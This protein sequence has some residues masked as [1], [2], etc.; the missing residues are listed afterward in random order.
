MYLKSLSI[1]GFK[2]FADK[3]TLKY[4]PGI[5]VIVGPN[6]SGKSNITDAI[7][8]VLG[9]Q[10]PR[11]LRGSAME[12]VIFTGSS[13][14]SPLGIAEVSLS[15]DNTDGCLPIEFSEVI[16]T[17]RMSRSGESDY[18]INGSSCRLLDVQDLLSDSGLGR[19]THSIVS[20]GRI[21]EI[22]SSKPEEKRVLIEEVAGV[23]KHRKRKERAL[24]KL[25]AM[26]QNLL[27]I[28]DVLREV[29]RQLRPLKKQ[30]SQAEKSLKLSHQLKNL[31]IA[32][33][34]AELKKLQSGWDD[35]MKENK[36]LNNELVALR[37]RLT[38]KKEEMDE[39]QLSLEE[40]GDYVGDIGEYR[41]RMKG[42]IERFNTG[43]LLLEEKGKHL[44]EKLSDIRRQIYQ[45]EK[46]K[47]SKSKE[48][49]KINSKISKVKSDVDD[50]LIKVGQARKNNEKLERNMQQI[51]K[52]L[53]ELRGAVAKKNDQLKIDE[54][55]ANLLLSSF[56]VTEIESKFAVEKITVLKNEKKILLVNLNKKEKEKSSIES[57]LM[58]LNDYLCNNENE[59]LKRS[60]DL[61]NLESQ[62][63]KIEGSLYGTKTKISALEEIEK[64]PTGYPESVVWLIFEKGMSGLHGI[65]GDLLD[66]DEGYENAIE[67]V[68]SENMYSIIASDVSVAKN[69]ICAL[70]QSNQ[71][72]TS[73]IPLKGFT[74]APMTST[75]RLGVI[76]AMDVVKCD[77]KVEPAIQ[78]ILGNL[79]IVDDLDTA[80]DL[81][82]KNSKNSVF[83]T[84]SGEVIFPNGII[85]GGNLSSANPLSRKRILA[86]LKKDEKIL[87]NNL[88]KTKK[89]IE[90]LK[91]NLKIF[92]DKK[93]GF[94]QE[95]QAIKSE[96][97][98]IVG[99]LSYLKDLTVKKE[100]EEKKFLSQN[101]KAQKKLC[102]D[103]KKIETLERKS[104]FLKKE[105]ATIE[106]SIKIAENDK[107]KHFIDENKFAREDAKLEV[108]KESLL[109]KLLFIENQRDITIRDVNEFNHTLKSEHQTVKAMEKLRERIQP[110]HKLFTVLFAEAKKWDKKLESLATD[111]KIDTRK[112][113]EKYRL[114]QAEMVP[115]N[116]EIDDTQ[117]RIKEIEVECAQLKLKVTGLTDKI[118]SEYDVPLEKALKIYPKDVDKDKHKEEAEKI[119]AKLA[120]LGTINPIA[121]KECGTLKERYEFLKDQILDLKK[122][123]KAL[124]RVIKIIEQKMKGRFLEAFNEVNVNFQNIFSYLF[125]GGKA[126]LLLTDEENLLTTGVEIEA[127]PLGKRLQRITL[128]SGGEKSLVALTLLFA[129]Y[130]TKP[131]PFYVLDEVEPALDDTNLQRFI[132]LLEKEKRE[133]QFL[134]ITHQR[135]TMEIADCLYGVA[136]QADGISKLVSQ[137][138]SGSERKNKVH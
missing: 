39:T 85:R 98:N 104:E 68:L 117:D 102:S 50:I 47:S 113:R 28:Q 106:N 119:R 109:E 135:R 49:D 20:Q 126:R 1:R 7:L 45:D 12:D 77:K 40:K 32:L 62:L 26:D 6:G 116:K 64:N 130:H 90:Q 84:L 19:Q 138:M 67:A 16:I 23:L 65:V 33:A 121:V 10:S 31:E 52:K 127:H 93:S 83:V 8:W 15:L 2:S 55:E 81:A 100:R 63:R 91:S 17:R 94:E 48:L 66:I 58:K 111:E 13:T 27:R 54:K 51:D 46:R 87:L 89:E 36:H 30:A 56:N 60:N 79:F 131:S 75:K 134:I 128:L 3:T 18:F 70:N 99:D 80:L 123:R 137:K 4:E 61:D 21:E 108:G 34:V 125:S 82:N 76:S 115:L 122:S 101:E 73:I 107:Q 103:K 22:L 41:R 124:G 11:S 44:V 72:A 105:I 74:R 38:N 5:T 92:V 69:V 9:E 59:I 132:V 71:E 96:R 114:T 136:M 24:R 112:L 110:L 35:V 120:D 129:M 29:E 37:K 97:Q 43:L 133:A 88:A 14:R 95:V 57:K 25:Q 118:V 78:A 86:K 42:I 53:S